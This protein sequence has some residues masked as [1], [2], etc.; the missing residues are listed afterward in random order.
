[1]VDRNVK[2]P[3]TISFALLKFGNPRRVEMQKKIILQTGQRN[4]QAIQ[5]RRNAIFCSSGW[6]GKASANG[7]ARSA[8]GQRGLLGFDGKG[9]RGRLRGGRVRRKIQ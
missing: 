8:H 1:M 7:R 4:R 6:L 3:G 9:K 2:D 5:Q